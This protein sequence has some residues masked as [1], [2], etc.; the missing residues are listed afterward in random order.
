MNFYQNVKSRRENRKGD[1]MEYEIVKG[2][3]DFGVEETDSSRHSFEYIMSDIADIKTSY[4]RLGFHLDEFKHNKY[5]ENYGYVSFEDFCEKNVSI[6][7]KSIERC[8]RVFYR[9]AELKGDIRRD[10]IDKKY[11]SY[12]YGQLC[13]MVSMKESELEEVTPAMSVKAIRNLKKTLKQQSNE[14]QNI[15]SDVAPMSK[16]EEETKQ[17]I[18]ENDE[19]GK[20]EFFVGDFMEEL[21]AFLESHYNLVGVEVSG[22]SV[23]FAKFDGDKYKSFRLMLSETK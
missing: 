6:D 2:L 1:F 10:K 12:N 13:E 5:H 20:E 15:K 23:F 16:K 7:K 14:N 4:I 8:L 9:F 22:K 3:F 21:Y 18:V 17:E 11:S 19:K